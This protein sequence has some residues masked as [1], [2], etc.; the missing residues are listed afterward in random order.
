MTARRQPLVLVRD[1]VLRR[2]TRIRE[3]DDWIDLNLPLAQA[4]NLLKAQVADA[5]ERAAIATAALEQISVEIPNSGTARAQRLLAA[6]VETT[7]AGVEAVAIDVTLLEAE[8]DD[9]AEATAVTALSTRVT[10]N[11]DEIEA[12]SDDL[13]ALEAEVDGIATSTALTELSARVTINEGDID[14]VEADVAT[15]AEAS[16]VTALS[17]RVTTAEGDLD[18]AED[19]I[20]AE[21]S[22]REALET[23]VDVLQKVL[24][25]DSIAT[26]KNGVDA[27]GE[28]A[29]LTSATLSSASTTRTDSGVQ[30]AAAILLYENDAS[31]VD[32]SDF[33][34]TVESGD[35]IRFDYSASIWYEFQVNGDVS[36]DGDRRVVP[37]ELLRH[38]NENGTT[39]LTST[40]D[41][42]FTFNRVGGALSQWT[43]KTRVGD[44]T[45]GI[46]LLNDGGTVRLYIVADRFAVLPAGASDTDDEVVPFIV[47]GGN[48]YM[49]TAIIRDGTIGSAKIGTLVATKITGLQAVFASL[50]V[51]WAQVQNAAIENAQIVSLEAGKITGLQAV[52][53]SLMVTLAQIG[54]LSALTI[55]A[56]QITAGVLSADHVSADVQNV[57][58]LSTATVTT[59]TTDT[60]REILASAMQWRIFISSNSTCESATSRARG[61]CAWPIFRKW[62]ILGSKAKK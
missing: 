30:S 24:E 4:V 50:T 11:E 46:G 53:N 5:L 3:G 20:V 17:S 38:E 60:Y 42:Q 29:F 9:K 34:D 61:R 8:V 55:D 18:D 48:V 32:Q 57:A 40:Q 14:D 10:T 35:I 39:L 28:Y 31:D 45:G 41:V 44:L 58:I 26:T 25:Y 51:D 59:L 56:D 23:R 1:P 36:T 19:D 12:V 27:A 16:S 49:D 62:S 43:V 33:L 52:F 54:D 37:V 7:E 21:A 22:A 2:E 47:S 15:K 6:R 13:T